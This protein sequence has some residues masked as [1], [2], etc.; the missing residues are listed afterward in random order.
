MDGTG[1]THTMST[2]RN[3]CDALD[4]ISVDDAFDIEG[5]R[6]LCVILRRT[7]C[8]HRIRRAES[9]LTAKL[10]NARNLSFVE[11]IPGGEDILKRIG[12]Q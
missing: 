2:A 3:S 12:V 10:S 8:E 9:L 7:R 4:F 1:N 11:A 5:V 6:L